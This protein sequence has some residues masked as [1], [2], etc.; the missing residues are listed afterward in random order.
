MTYADNE[1]VNK[2]LDLDDQVLSNKSDIIDNCRERSYRWI[3]HQF[4]RRGEDSPSTDTL[5]TE[6]QILIDIE[7]DLSAYYYR[8]DRTEFDDEEKGYKILQW[9]KD[10]EQ[11]LN[12]YL[13]DQYPSTYYGIGGDD[14]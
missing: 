5:S 10:A 12:N 7:A 3:Q 4:A 2:R 11:L 13:R 6:D 14:D 8:R 1:D 9:K